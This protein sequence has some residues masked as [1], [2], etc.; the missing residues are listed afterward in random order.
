[1]SKLAVSLTTTESGR[2]TA[3]S[4]LCEQ[5]YS[6]AGADNPALVHD[7]NYDPSSGKQ[8]SSPPDPNEFASADY[9]LDASVDLVPAQASSPPGADD[10]S[11]ERGMSDGL[12]SATQSSAPTTSSGGI[13]ADNVNPVGLCLQSNVPIGMFYG[14]RR[15]RVPKKPWRYR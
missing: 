5:A 12:H 10:S 1:M 13:T 3:P 9:C 8:A 4:S 6:S 7:V 2:D 14:P 15:G 11:A